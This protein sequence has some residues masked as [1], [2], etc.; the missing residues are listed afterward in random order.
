MVFEGD[1]GAAERARERDRMVE[2]A[3]GHQQG[4]GAERMELARGQLGHLART[5]QHHGLVAERV[6]DLS[7]QAHRGRADRDRAAADKRRLAHPLGDRERA[8]KSA[9]QH[10]A[11]G[12]RLGRV[13]VRRA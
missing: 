2:G 9:M 12:A 8:M 7:G 1:G 10:Q 11:G 3:A 4:L 6:E 13:A 5:H